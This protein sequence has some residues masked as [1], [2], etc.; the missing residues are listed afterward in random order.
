MDDSLSGEP[1][2]LVLHCPHFRAQG[3]L[4]P[5]MQRSGE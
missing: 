1:G 3:G 4:K 2:K 5:T